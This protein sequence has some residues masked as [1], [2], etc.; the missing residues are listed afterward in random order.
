MLG[1]MSAMP[2]PAKYGVV[3]PV[4]PPAHAKSRLMALGD[5]MRRRLVVAFAG[6]TVEAVLACAC[7]AEVLV[8]TDDHELAAV[9]AELGA[10]VIPD[11]AA[12][13]LNASVVLGAAELHRVH[14][15]LGVAAV[16]ADLPALRPAELARALGEA[17]PDRMSFVSDSDGIGTTTVLAPAL[18][19]FAPRF[20]PASRQAHREAGAHEIGLPDV[21]GLRRDIDTPADLVVALRIGVGPRT[22]AVTQQGALATGDPDSGH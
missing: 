9:M 17:A 16:C 21:P 2:P 5:S 13:D 11:G 7:V 14:P 12:D 8:V 19:T 3:V 1:K 22:H 18:A 4:K 20:G 6:D 15:A 10:R